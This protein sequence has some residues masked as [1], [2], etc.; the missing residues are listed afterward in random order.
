VGT[1]DESTRRISKGAVIWISPGH[2]RERR[3]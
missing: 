3:A 2:I 1:C